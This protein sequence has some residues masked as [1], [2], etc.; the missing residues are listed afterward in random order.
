MVQHMV[1]MT[2]IPIFLVVG[3]P[4]TLA[5]RALPAR[6]DDSRGPREWILTIV[7]SHVARFVA[8]PIVAAVNFAGR[9]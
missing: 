3:A 5:L 1:L 2:V 9:W 4:V 8:N 6:P 7:N